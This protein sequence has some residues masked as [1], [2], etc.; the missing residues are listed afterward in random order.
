VLLANVHVAVSTVDDAAY[1]QPT[2]A[3]DSD[4]HEVRAHPNRPGSWWPQP[5]SGSAASHD[6]GLTWK[7]NRM[8][9]SSHS[10]RSRL[11][12]MT[13]RVRIGGPL[14]GT[15]GNLPTKDRWR[16]SLVAVAGGL[17]A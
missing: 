7:E 14:R 15:G 1:L 16:R 13:S 8:S 9:A 17:P 5:R 12:A 11:A 10:P 2:I 4:V 3:I 6:S